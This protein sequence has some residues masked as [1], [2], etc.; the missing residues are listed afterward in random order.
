MRSLDGT[1][2]WLTGFFIALFALPPIA[3]F[4]GFVSQR[5][6]W[7][8]FVPTEGFILLMIALRGPLSRMGRP[9]QLVAWLCFG[10]AAAGVI[11]FSRREPFSLANAALMGVVLAAVAFLSD[12]FRSKREAANG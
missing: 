8:N 3:L 12:Y 9:L 4:A 5:S 11:A 1:G 10:A 7:T 6:F 2:Q